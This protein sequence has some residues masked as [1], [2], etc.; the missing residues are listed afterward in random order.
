MV[1]IPG[2]EFSMG[3]DAAADALCDHPGITRDA[4]PIHRVA[5]D[6]FWNRMPTEVTNEQF[7]AFVKA[8]AYV[9]VAE[10]PP[11]PSEFPGVAARVSGSRLHALYAA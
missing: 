10:Q 9:T 1:W 5:V 11:N 2:G 7:A 8:T 6:G 3:S 4:Q